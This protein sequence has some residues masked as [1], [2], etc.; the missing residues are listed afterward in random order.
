MLAQRLIDEYNED[1]AKEVAGARRR[2]RRP[3][4]STE[5]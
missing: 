1:K 3:R 2:T 5:K 4:P